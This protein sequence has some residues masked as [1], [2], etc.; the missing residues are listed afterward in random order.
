M[1]IEILVNVAPGETR[2]AQV[3]N[4]AVQEV[5]LQRESRLSVAGNIYLGRVQRV[6]PGM[7]AAFVEIGLA[8]T[9]F[10][11]ANDV[12][13]EAATEDEP[14]PGIEQ[15]LAVDEPVLVQVIK[16]PLGSKGA[17]LSTAVS[18]PSRYLVLMPT[19]ERLAVSVRIEDAA[20]R[21]RLLALL[22]K[23]KAESGLAGGFIVRTAGEG[24]DRDALAADMRFLSRLWTWI[25]AQ[26]AAVEPP[27]LVHKDLPMATRLLRDLLGAGVERIRI[28]DQ[29]AWQEMVAF[30]RR[31]VPEFEDRIEHYRGEAPIFDL[32]G[33]EDDIDRAL[34]P[35]VPLKSGGSLVIEQTEAMST[36]DVNT[37]AF[38]G[39]R[40]LEDTILKTNLEAAQTLARQLRLRNLGGIIIVDFID[41]VSEAHREQVVQALETALARDPA[42]SAIFPISPLGLVQM[43]RKRTRES[44]EHLLCE[45]CPACGGRGSVKTPESVCLEIF[46]EVLRSARQFEARALLVLANADV[47]AVLLDE[48]AEALAAVSESINRPIRLQAESLYQQ[49]QFDVV[50][51]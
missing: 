43:T 18:I 31:L 23:L 1:G 20:E 24:A 33:V 10:L 29:Q 7:Q 36:V 19:C 38:V 51:M 2:I 17:R 37:G 28:D 32:Y 26:M 12:A 49:E 15:M 35:L 5:Y 46:R 39:S 48:Q 42:K 3:E 47:V 8:R 11:H 6:L 44:L 27:G 25:G 13:R 16:E 14:V 40:R 21:E 41:M 45:T 4:G 22:A 9:A 34:Q 30:A 50:L